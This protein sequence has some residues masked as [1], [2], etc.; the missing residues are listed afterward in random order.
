[1]ARRRPRRALRAS[2]ARRTPGSRAP[3]VD[4]VEGRLRG[5][6]IATPERVEAETEAL[7]GAPLPALARLRARPSR[8]SRRCASSRPGCSARRTAS[9]ARPSAR[10]RALDLRAHETCVRL[11]D[12]LERWARAGEPLAPRGRRRR[13]RAARRVRGAARRRARARRRRSTCC[14]RG[15][16]GS[17][18]SSCS[19]SRRAACRAAAAPR[20]SSTTTRAAALG[21]RLERPDP[22]SRDRYLFY[23]ACTRAT[24][25]LYLVREAATDEGSPREPSPFWDEVQARLRRR[26]TS[27]ARRAAG[28]SR[29]SRG[30]SRT[31][32]S[33]RERLRALAA[34]RVRPGRARDRRGAR[35][36]DTAGSGG[37]TA[38]SAPSRGPTRLRHPARA[39]AARARGRRFNVTELERFA[40][41]SSAWL[42]DRVR[43]SED[44][45]RRGRREAARLGRA[46]GALPLLHRAAE[47]ARRRARRPA[48]VEQAVGFMRACLD[49]APSRACAWR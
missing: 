11:L 9:S 32:P 27:R 20:R 23:T 14:A 29:R 16:A 33:E 6:A 10:R 22:V 35:A 18:P 19:G 25:R 26:T 12:E 13:A 8:P 34:A 49:E 4:F 1:M 24:R 36:R 3:S 42:F 46:H 38:R 30:R 7:R 15:R 43:R 28:R 44:D 21:A 45:R 2:C 41:C 31:A 37:S 48:H 17:R 40:D 5:R 47:G 39:R